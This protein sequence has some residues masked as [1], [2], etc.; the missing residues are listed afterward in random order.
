MKASILSALIIG[1]NCVQLQR[2]DTFEL[3]DKTLIEFADGM[4]EDDESQL[5]DN[6][7]KVENFVDQKQAKINK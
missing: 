6:H 4:T 1:T 5:V 3:L 7:L 2:Y